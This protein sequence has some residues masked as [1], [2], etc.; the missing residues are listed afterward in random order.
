MKGL[1]VIKKLLTVVGVALLLLLAAPTT[2]SAAG[3]SDACH[4]IAACW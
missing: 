1:S 2:A 3:E 4:L